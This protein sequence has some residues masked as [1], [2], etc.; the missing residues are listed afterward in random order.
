MNKYKDIGFKLTPQR[1]AI[2]D[3]L[4]GNIQHPSA[5]DIYQ[6]VL[7]KFP[8][9]SFATVYTT[10]AAL[11]QK[12]KLLE[13]TVDPEKKRY[14]PDTKNHSHLLCESCS[15]VF[16]IP[17]E[18]TIVLP[19]LVKRNFFITKSHLEFNGICPECKKNGSW[20]KTQR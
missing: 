1:L 5:D 3:Y 8:T 18:Y 11:K 19:E 15:R 7:K 6:A 13:L 17:V 9:I 4:E 16:D 12:G 2:L 10:L 14:D 20:Q